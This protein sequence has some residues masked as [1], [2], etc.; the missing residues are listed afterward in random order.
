MDVRFINPFV[1][2]IQ[3][4]F[5]TMISVDTVIGKPFLKTQEGLDTE[6][7]AVIGLSG[8]AVGSVVLCFPRATA[9]K[10]ATAFSG[11]PMSVKP[12]DFG[13]ALGELVNM[14]T[15]NAKSR[16]KGV[17]CDIS[18]PNVLSGF[19]VKVHQ[20]RRDATLVLPCDSTM[21]HFRVEVTMEMKAKAEAAA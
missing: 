9:V 7:S 8:D 16:F 5:K 14:V 2:A 17:S 20:V 13:D 3:H 18:L 19:D 21:G 12:P 11:E 6:V 4:V 15:G 10:F 1:N